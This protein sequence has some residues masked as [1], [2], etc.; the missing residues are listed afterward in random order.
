MRRLTFLLSLIAGIAGRLPA[1]ET[2]LAE[3]SGQV[4][5]GYQGWFRAEGDD[6][7]L[8][9][10]HFG[11]GKTFAPGAC[12]FDLWPDLAEFTPSELYPS[13]FKFSNGETAPLFSSV[14][15]LTVRRHFQWMKAYGIHGA[16][17]QRFA[18]GLN[19]PRQKKSMDVVL[20]N[21]L[22]AAKAEGVTL[23][24]MYD[25]S[26]LKPEAF[27]VVSEDW[28]TLLRQGW[29]QE[30][31]I[32][33]FHGQPLVV[34]WGLGFNDRPAALTEWTQLLQT[35]KKTAASV[36]VGVPTYWRTQK[37][38]AIT[39]PGLLNIIRMADIIS[40]WTV[41]RIGKPE[42][43][44]D[45]L[46]ERVWKP[47]LGWCTQAK[48]AYLPVIFPG[49][50][51]HNLQALRGQNSAP[52]QIP[53]LGGQFFWRQAIEAQKAGADALYIAMFDEIDEGT[54]IMKC[55]GRRPEGASPFV[56]LSDVPTDH[57]LWL[58]EQIGKMLRREI[59]AS[60]NLPAR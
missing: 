4:F 19:S 51:W 46:A 58:S 40:P 26:G 5:C 59:P 36:M 3:L 1:T 9:W 6:S 31:C 37:N 7:G 44:Q 45:I 15:P 34:T 16:F 13:P 57:Y 60:D 8:G 35:L 29:A 53:R 25:L 38:D 30:S 42:A 47:D 39:D 14:N 32:Q 49:F 11:P 2:P 20:Q 23:T 22:A 24:V 48:K 18:V 54:A 56:D 43:A 41:G 21:C 28:Q 17:L 10:T 52:N 27:T 12:A 50:S 33:K 55:G